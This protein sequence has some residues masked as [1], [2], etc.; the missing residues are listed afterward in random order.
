M[1]AA[2]SVFT[3][4]SGTFGV[5]RDHDVHRHDE[6]L[7]LQPVEQCPESDSDVHCPEQFDDQRRYGRRRHGRWHVNL[8]V[9]GHARRALRNLERWVAHT[10]LGPPRRERRDRND[11]LITASG[12]VSFAAGVTTQPIAITVCRDASFEIDEAFSSA[13][14]VRPTQRS[15]TARAPARSRTT[16]R[17]RPSRSITS[18][19]TEGIDAA[20]DVHLHG[21]K[22]GTTDVSAAVGYA[23][24]HGNGDRAAPAARA[25]STTSPRRA[26]SPSGW[27]DNPDDRSHGLSRRH[28][29]GQRDVQRRRYRVR[30]TRRSRTAR[31]PARSRMTM[32]PRRSPSTIRASPREPVGGRRP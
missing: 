14:L 4:W 11:G 19:L 21:H 17:R 22:T 15:A 1:P 29:R 27:R 8:H 18:A 2:G 10:S 32:L 13:W 7:H 24:S 25:P 6:S 16:T 5:R 31:G 3:G 9:H 12:T 30:R 28:I 20:Q 26:R 23:T